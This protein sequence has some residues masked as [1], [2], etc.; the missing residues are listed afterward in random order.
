MDVVCVCVRLRE[1]SLAW[2]L[3]KW[4]TILEMTRPEVGI[5]VT[6]NYCDAFSVVHSL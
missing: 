6:W 5:K 1:L 4:S 3:E 2:P